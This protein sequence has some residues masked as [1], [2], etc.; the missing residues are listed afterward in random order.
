MSSTGFPR[1]GFLV[2]IGAIVYDFLVVLAVL[3][4][5]VA[6]AL[7]FSVA[8]DK[9]GI[10]PLGEAVDHA[11]RL[12]GSILYTLYLLTVLFGFFALFWHRGGQTLGMKAWRLRVQNENGKRISWKQAFLRSVTAIVGLGNLRVIWA[13]DKLAWQ[14]KIAKCEVVRLT[15]EANQF[16]NWKEQQR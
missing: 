11:D 8:L 13:K 4:F 9:T 3:M 16:K 6:V 7:A 1:A 14:D 15:P 2:R 5:A 12:S 10:W